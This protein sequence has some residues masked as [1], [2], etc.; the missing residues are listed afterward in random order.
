MKTADLRLLIL[1]MFVGEESYGYGVHKRLAAMSK[2][3]EIG[4]LY[5]VLNKM[6]KEQL[7]ESVWQKSSKGPRKKLYR[8]SEKGR[9]ELDELLR[10]AIETIR[11][12]YA[13][14]LTNLPLKASVFENI[15]K[16]LMKDLRKQGAIAFVAASSSSMHGRLLSSLQS[17]LPKCSIFV[18]RPKEVDVD[19][20]LRDMVPLEGDYDGVPLKHNSVDLLIMMGLPKKAVLQDAVWEWFRV[21]KENGKLMIVVPT[22]LVRRIK[23]PLRIGDFMEKMEH[24]VL[25]KERFVDCSLILGLLRNHFE[26]VE[27]KQIVNMT[28]IIASNPR[29]SS[30]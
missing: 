16:L 7:L 10:N 13:E 22:V 19:L 18:V 1:K 6:L 26:K 17:R 20:H 8:I 28:L 11:F 3:V 2:H 29:P 12:S 27:T 23:D 14:Y 5:K 24:N 30:L 21:M 15:S 9:K 25:G 4:Q